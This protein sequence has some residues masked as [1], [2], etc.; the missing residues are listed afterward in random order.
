MHLRNYNSISATVTPGTAMG[1]NHSPEIPTPDLYLQI[2]LGTETSDHPYNLAGHWFA[3]SVGKH[4]AM[5][6]SG[7]GLVPIAVAPNSCMIIIIIT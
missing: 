3:C 4:L 5:D 6:I 1:T 2:I 7:P